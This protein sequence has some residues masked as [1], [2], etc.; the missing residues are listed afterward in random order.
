MR[1]SNLVSHLSQEA[2]DNFLQNHTFLLQSFCVYLVTF[3][4]VISVR[5]PQLPPGVLQHCPHVTFPAGYKCVTDT[6]FALQR[7]N[8][9][10]RKQKEWSCMPTNW[11]SPCTVEMRTKKSHLLPLPCKCT[12]TGSLS[13]HRDE[14]HP[15]LPA[16]LLLVRL[17][18]RWVWTAA[19]HPQQVALASE[20]QQLQCSDTQAML[21]DVVDPKAGHFVIK[22]LVTF[23]LFTTFAAA[24]PLW[25]AMRDRWIDCISSI[26]L[27]EIMWV[28]IFLPKCFLT[29]TVNTAAPQTASSSQ[30][31]EPCERRLYCGAQP[32]QG[33]V[34]RK[35]EGTAKMGAW[36]PVQDREQHW[37]W[38]FIHQQSS[39]ALAL[40]VLPVSFPWFEGKNTCGHPHCDSSRIPAEVVGKKWRS[41][42]AVIA[43][44][45]HVTQ[46]KKG[47]DDPGEDFGVWARATFKYL[48]SVPAPDQEPKSDCRWIY[49]ANTS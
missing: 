19:P 23:S 34:P 33:E 5:Q 15:E 17:L 35:A 2:W 48:Y 39:T 16:I 11:G 1:A 25:S 29:R 12:E 8:E 30:S 24:V 40:A 26:S 27:G 13:G 47:K 32:A 14:C 46:S 43:I 49:P 44:R 31:Q 10:K 18:R 42:E 45:D 9:R 4:Y 22:G 36:K 21:R 6:I 41:A 37:K 7:E 28:F 38:T 20:A 3:T